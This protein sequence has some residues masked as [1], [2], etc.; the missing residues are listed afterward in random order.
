MDMQTL[1]RSLDKDARERLASSA[2]TSVGYLYLIAG[3]H[4]KPSPTLARK[5]VD[6]EERLTLSELRP[7]LWANQNPAVHAE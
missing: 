6:V 4:R 2:D 1:L 5:L 7:D 3:G